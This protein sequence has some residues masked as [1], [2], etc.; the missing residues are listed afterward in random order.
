MGSTATGIRTDI[1]ARLDRLPWSNRHWKIVLALGITRILDGLEVTIVGAIGA[2][3]T[4]RN[5]LHSSPSEVGAIGGFYIVGRR[6]GRD[7]L[8]LLH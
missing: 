5:T 7:R 1:P 2:R 4:E 3:L 6:T 8:R